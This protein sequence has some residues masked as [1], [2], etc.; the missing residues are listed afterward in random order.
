MTV[1]VGDPLGD[2][3]TLQ[4]GESPVQRGTEGGRG[5]AAAAEVSNLRG[6]LRSNRFLGSGTTAA[7][8]WGPGR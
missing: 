6:G 7:S 8:G 5:P 2:L 3:Q 1:E 4:Q